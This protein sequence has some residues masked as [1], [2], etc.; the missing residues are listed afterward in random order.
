M[1][2]P[3][4]HT[5][6]V[7]TH[8]RFLVRPPA[9]GRP[10]R[11]AVVGFHGYG[12][13]AEDMLGELEAFIYKHAGQELNIGSPKQLGELLFD[14]LGLPT[15]GVRRTKLGWSTEAEVLEER[16]NEHAII[17]PILE[18]REI[19]KLKSTYVDALP[20]LINPETGRVHTNYNQ[21]GT[22]TGRISSNGPNASCGTSLRLTV[23]P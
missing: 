19:S 2:A 12:Q 16:I 17:A 22:A 1:P 14:K 5:I 10:A 18:H 8:G 21:T 9:A 20:Q 6:G 13:R 7:T 3:A 11:I 4:V 15:K 23:P